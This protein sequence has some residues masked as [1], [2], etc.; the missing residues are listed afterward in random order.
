MIERMIY[1][2]RKFN[3]SGL[4]G[5]SDKTLEMRRKESIPSLQRQNCP[6]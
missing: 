1:K 5:I 6:N 3:L 2:P 4:K